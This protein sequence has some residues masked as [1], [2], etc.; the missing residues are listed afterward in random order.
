[1]VYSLQEFIL[2]TPSND[3]RYDVYYRH[4]EAFMCR[5]E[6]FFHGL[7]GVYFLLYFTCKQE[8]M[9]NSLDFEGSLAYAGSMIRGCAISC[10]SSSAPPLIC[11][12]VPLALH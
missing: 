2:L 5:L 7:R 6:V 9:F 3:K 1:M 8:E 10:S 11:S 4:A 12:Q